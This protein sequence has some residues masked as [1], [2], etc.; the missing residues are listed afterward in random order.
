MRSLSLPAFHQGCHLSETLE[1]EVSLLSVAYPACGH[2]MALSL[3]GV[4]SSAFI[5]LTLNSIKAYETLIISFL[6]SHYSFT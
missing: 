3:M 5:V 4:H 1:G 2:C 6:S